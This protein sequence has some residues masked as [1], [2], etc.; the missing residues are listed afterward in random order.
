MRTSKSAELDGHRHCARATTK[1]V[2]TV[3]TVET[4]M[5]MMTMM[6]APSERNAAQKDSPPRRPASYF[7]GRLPTHPRPQSRR[8]T[9]TKSTAC[10]LATTSHHPAQSHCH[11]SRARCSGSNSPSPRRSE[12]PT[13]AAIEAPQ[14]SKTMS[15]L[16][17]SI[18][19]AMQT[20][21]TARVDSRAT[22]PVL[23]YWRMTNFVLRQDVGPSD[24]C[25][26]T[27]R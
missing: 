1:T 3:E 18:K 9:A 10:P 16:V 11:S 22:R 12:L 19:N 23:L 20:V 6:P 21:E 27:Y 2:E 17:Y 8:R 15:L 7:P 13:A 26:L 25:P 5:T 14:T 24:R 4:M